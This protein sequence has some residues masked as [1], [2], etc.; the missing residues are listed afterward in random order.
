MSDY[1]LRLLEDQIQANSTFSSPLAAGNRVLYVVQGEVGTLVE[2][3]SRKVA[4]NDAWYT[5]AACSIKSGAEGARL[6]RWELVPAPEGHGGL[7]T[8]ESVA[9]T[10]KLSH[11]VNLD[12]RGGYLM[13][14]DRVDFPL[15]VVAY[16]HTHQGSGIRCLL[17]GELN[18]ETGGKESRIRPGEAWFEKGPDPVYAAAS[19]E[20]PTSFIRVMILPAA[21]KGKSSIRY[22][23]A[24]DRDRP[25]TQQYTVFVDELIET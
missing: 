14:C 15:G 2:G 12:P 4:A 3:T 24:G 8:G 18:V 5:G 13:R 22:V 25:K 16:S 7:A 10:P 17:R 23:N 19:H 20:K 9:S 1:V 21:L 11:E 6:W